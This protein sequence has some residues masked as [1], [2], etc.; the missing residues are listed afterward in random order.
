MNIDFDG[1]YYELKYAWTLASS[2][3]IV[4]GSI[5][6]GGEVQLNHWNSGCSVGTT[7]GW[8]YQIKY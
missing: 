8:S 1:K 7:C 3:S 2:E 5:E 6:I 4:L